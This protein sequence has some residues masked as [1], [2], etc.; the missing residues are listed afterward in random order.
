MLSA[1][2][3]SSPLSYLVLSKDPNQLIRASALRVLSSIRVS[4]IVPIMQIAL[5]QV[6]TSP[7]SRSHTCAALS[8]I[9]LF[10]ILHRLVPSHHGLSQ[11]ASDMSPY[12]RKTA[13]HA[14]PKL[15]E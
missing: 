2:V 4:V 8:C 6:R 14:L 10:V 7:L 12:V 15:Y 11:A 1:R 3:C 13:A 5:K 9:V